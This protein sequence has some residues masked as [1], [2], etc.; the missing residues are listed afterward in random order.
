MLKCQK[1][2][3][4]R[5][6]YGTK[7]MS[8]KKTIMIAGGGT[9]GHIYPAI[10][11]G[12]ALLKLDPSLR[13]RF[14]GTAEGL[15]S[16]IMQRENLALDLIQSGKLNFSG[17]PLRKIK[18]LFKIPVGFFQSVLLLLKYKPEFVLGVGGY[19]SAPFVLMAA[20][21]GRKTAIW[22]P[23]AHPGMANRILSR[24][25]SKSYLVFDSSK[26]Y[27]STKDNKVFGMPLREEIESVQFEERSKISEKL[28]ILCF[29]GSQGSLFLNEKMSEFILPNESLHEKI[30]LIHQTGTQDFEKMK[31]KY[32]KLSC[33]EVHEFI[34][35]MPQQYRNADIQFCRGGASTIAEASA[36]GVVPLIVPLPA[37]DDHQL[38]NAEVVVQN[39]AGYLFKQSEFNSSEFQ[40]TIE[41]L[42]SNPDLR[43]E[44][45]ANLRKLAPQH[46]ANRIAQDVLSEIL[47]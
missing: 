32:G 47:T 2:S 21:L 12:R 40:K 8:Y 37:A 44:L 28:T 27:L 24:L 1:I 38:R 29:G 46:A 41:S 45:S 35:D 36:F 20:I 43:K 26:K 31:L 16:K 30:Y 17:N 18:T 23:N 25:V 4:N 33:V 6:L 5:P 19:A 22:E 42:L 15:E 11:I 7:N 34:Y 10:A 39:K 14:V 9:G 13:V 3:L